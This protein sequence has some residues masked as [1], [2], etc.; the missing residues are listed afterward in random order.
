MND[1][2]N[3]LEDMPPKG[4]AVLIAYKNSHDNWRTVKAVW[5]GRWTEECDADS[6]A[7][8]EYHEITDCF[9]TTEGWYEQIDNWGDFSAV[10]VYEENIVNHWHPMPAPPGAEL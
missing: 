8:Y 3:I 9:Y 6:E 7:D 2:T 1:W 10:K 5:V 4:C